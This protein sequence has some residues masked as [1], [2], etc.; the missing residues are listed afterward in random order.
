[1]KDYEIENEDDNFINEEKMM[2]YVITNLLLN[3]A[4]SC[5]GM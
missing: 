3:H 5:P 4:N 1:M 2:V